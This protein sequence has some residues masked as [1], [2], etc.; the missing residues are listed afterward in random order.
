MYKAQQQDVYRLHQEQYGRSRYA[1]GTGTPKDYDSLKRQVS[2]IPKK[3]DGS[4]TID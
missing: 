1:S 2:M 3:V 4:L